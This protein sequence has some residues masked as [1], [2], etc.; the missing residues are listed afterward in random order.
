MFDL[1]ADIRVNTVNCVGVMGAGVALAFKQRYPEMYRDYAKACRAGAVK[2]GRMHVWKPLDG[3]WIINFPTKR[4][5]RDPSRYEDIEAGLDDLRKYLS[6]LGPV[7]VA[8]PAL[9]CGHGGLDWERVAPMI[10]AKLEALEANIHVYEPSNS[11]R[12]GSVASVS[13]PDD[14]REA[15]RLGYVTVDHVLGIQKAEAPS[16]LVAGPLNAFDDPWVAV[17]PSRAPEGRELGALRAI[18]AELQRRDAKT[19]VA[20]IYNSRAS[21]GVVDV[22]LEAG[23]N[24]I[25]ILPFGVLTR[26][27]VAR[28]KRPEGPSPLLI[29]LTTPSAKWSPATLSEAM[30]FLRSKASAALVSDPEPAWLSPRAVGQWKVPLSYVR[31]EG[32][33]AK[34]EQLLAQAGSR[35]IGRQGGTGLPNVDSLLGRIGREASPIAQGNTVKIALPR[36]DDRSASASSFVDINLDDYSP[37][38]WSEIFHVLNS[39]CVRKASIAIETDGPEAAKELRAAL[40]TTRDRHLPA[41]GRR[42]TDARRASKQHR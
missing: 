23:L 21:E 7:S 41:A 42:I 24:P 29:S 20:L 38:A 18:A 12:L 27:S 28:L 17:I 36:P 15:E 40:A 16:A 33:P 4:D 11:R 5:W 1:P 22:F 35:P 30:K 25:V 31:Y 19:R 34:M 13:N 8:L 39:L 14:F 10:S 3:D 32:A 6:P 26:K 2:P 37:E 9:G